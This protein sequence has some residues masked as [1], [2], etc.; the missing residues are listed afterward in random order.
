M[1]KKITL[2]SNFSNFK[3]D[4]KAD[5][6]LDADQN[7]ELYIQYYNARISDYNLQINMEIMNDIYGLL[8]K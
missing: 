8:N 7:I 1:S 2:K 4:F 6:G 3:K 5:T